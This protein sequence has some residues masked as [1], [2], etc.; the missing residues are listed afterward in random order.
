MIRPLALTSSIPRMQPAIRRV[1][2]TVLAAAVGTFGSSTAGFMPGAAA[3]AAVLQ[4]PPPSPVETDA[5]P[6]GFVFAV[7]RSATSP[8][9]VSAPEPLRI[10]NASIPTAA[11]TASVSEPWIVVSPASGTSPAIATVSLNPAGVAV[12]TRGF[13]VGFISLVTPSAPTAPPRVVRVVLQITDATSITVPPIGALDAPANNAVGLSGAVPVGGW[14]ADDVG[15]ARVLIFRNAVGGEPPGEI[16]LGDGT[17]V[18]GAR[19]DVVSVISAPGVTSAGWGLMVLS[20]ALPPNGNGTFTL[21]AYAEDVEGN[22][23]LLGR[24]TVTFDNT[25]SILPFGT[26]DIPG[27]GATVSGM[28]NNQGWILAQPGRLIPFDGST[29]RLFIDGVAQ[30]NVA[31]YGFP[32]PDVAALFPF[33]TYANVNGPA[34]QFTF[35]T[36]LFADGLH[37]I[38]WTVVDNLGAVQGIGSRYFNI[39]NQAASQ[40]IGAAFVEA[41]SASELR[42]VRQAPAFIWERTGFDADRWSLRWSGTEDVTEI[43]HARGERLEVTLQ[44]WWSQGC[45]PY[46][47]YLTIGDVAGP[48]PPGASFDADAAVLTWVPPV[49]FSGTFDFTFVRRVCAGGEERIPLRITIS[50]R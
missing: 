34:A 22:R 42:T 28:L 7:H 31:A 1:L 18:R 26:I 21:S 45:G 39:R 49:E 38:V 9:H 30:P 6:N 4:P 11:W 41:R 43:Q 2:R 15:V 13:Y 3:A 32:R 8:E 10:T 24:T 23:T 16:F 14:A 29:I 35:D 50:P 5:P 46:A 48:L 37:T 17:R 40:A 47:A 19:P 33:P 27:Q 36:R 25:G 20:N 12:L 44:N